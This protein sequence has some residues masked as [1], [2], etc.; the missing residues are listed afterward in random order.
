MHFSAQA[1][2]AEVFTL[3]SFNFLSLLPCLRAL[4]HG[5]HCRSS[6]FPFFPGSPRATGP[7]V[8]LSPA[9]IVSLS[10]S[11][12]FSTDFGRRRS[13][14]AASV[15]RS[16]LPSSTPGRPA[17]GARV[18]Q[19]CP[20]FLP[21]TRARPSHFRRSRLVPPTLVV[22]ASE[23]ARAPRVRVGA[24]YSSRGRHARFSA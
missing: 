8:R 15:H 12:P 6:S 4:S 19:R 22:P 14:T 3:F 23:R 24:C 10:R 20:I 9:S 13:A 7:R 17:A 2:R 1:S 16:A 11:L 18:L 5:C 21:L